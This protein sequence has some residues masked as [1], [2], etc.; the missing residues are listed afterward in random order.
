MAVVITKPRDAGPTSSTLGVP[1]AEA[2]LA[3]SGGDSS[4]SSSSTMARE[5]PAAPPRP[6]GDLSGLASSTRAASLSQEQQD[7]RADVRAVRAAAASVGGAPPVGGTGRSVKILDVPGEHGAM[8]MATVKD[9]NTGIAPGVDASITRVSMTPAEAPTP[10]G[11]LLQDSSAWSGPADPAAVAAEVRAAQEAYDRGTATT[12]DIATLGLAG[13]AATMAARRAGES[14]DPVFQD[15]EHNADILTR[16]KGKDEVLDALKDKLH[17]PGTSAVAQAARDAIDGWATGDPESLSNGL[18]K[19][20]AHAID[21]WSAA[22][23]QTHSSDTTKP[24]FTAIPDEVN[25][26]SA[27]LEDARQSLWSPKFR[28]ENGLA[29]LSSGTPIPEQ[30]SKAYKA[31]SRRADEISRAAERRYARDPDVLAAQSRFEAI[32]KDKL[33]NE[34]MVTIVSAGNGGYNQG[35]RNFL[36][37]P[38][39]LAVG[40]TTDFDEAG[41]SADTTMAPYSAESADISAPGVAFDRNG[42]SEPGTSFSA[43]Y[44]AGAAALVSQQAPTLSAREIIAV[45]KETATAATGEHSDRAGAGIINVPDAVN[46]AKTLETRVSE[47]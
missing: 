13:M 36:D 16:G 23:D 19:S 10:L 11:T 45:I 47:E 15:P 12:T 43:P 28:D 2:S 37:T 4:A 22:L 30:M 29:P 9:P 14:V 39:V 42:K 46:R 21:A 31:V 44:L 24:S 18:G 6:L 8:A 38:S 1:G 33:E 27:H 26:R 40:S 20:V 5:L 35:S 32:A 34:N 7:A 3:H 41:A 17:D 25:T